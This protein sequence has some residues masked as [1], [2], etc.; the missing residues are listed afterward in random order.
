MTSNMGALIVFTTVPDEFLAVK[1]TEAVL[2]QSFAV[3]VNVLHVGQSYYRWQGMIESAAEIMLVIKTS[4]AR[5][6]ELEAEIKRLHTYDVPEILALD[7]KDGLPA[8]LEW[9]ANES[10]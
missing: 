5:Y 3:C 9:I 2:Q 8:Y 7:V 1:I 4:R 6:P 10:K